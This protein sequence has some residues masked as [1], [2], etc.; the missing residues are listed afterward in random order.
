M[1]IQRV[2][3]SYGY[4]KGQLNNLYNS[5]VM[6]VFLYETEVWSAAYQQKYLDK[7][8]RSLKRANRFGFTTKKTTILDLIKDRDSDSELF[9][10]ATSDDHIPHDLLPPRKRRVLR[11]RMYDFIYLELNRTHCFLNRCLFN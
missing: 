8:D 2:C 9:K 4:S 3:K 11:E 5:L 10:N 7:I 1:H 6:S